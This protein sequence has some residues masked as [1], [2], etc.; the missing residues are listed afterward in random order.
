MLDFVDRDG[1]YPDTIFD[2]IVDITEVENTTDYAYDLTV[3]ITRS[4]LIYNQVTV[5][6]TFHHC[7]MAIATVITGVPRFGE[8]LNAT[9][10]P[11]MVSCQIYFKQNDETLDGLRRYIGS[12]L[13]Q[14][15]LRDL[16]TSYTVTD[17]KTEEPWYSTYAMFRTMSENPE[18]SGSENSEDSED[19]EDSWIRRLGTQKTRK[20]GIILIL[21]NYVVVKIIV[22]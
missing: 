3:E 12:S 15:T 18:D 19:S 17:K 8:L 10:S 20:M 11:K 6:D 2:E 1:E 14:F 5:F 21:M 16:V 13:R 22:V 9:Q 7:G 4:F